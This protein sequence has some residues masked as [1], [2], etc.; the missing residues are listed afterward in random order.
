[1]SQKEKNNSIFDIQAN[2]GEDLIPKAT[3]S[4]KPL[5]TKK[6]TNTK[7]VAPTFP[8]EKD[9]KKTNNIKAK[10][11]KKGQKKKKQP[12]S[13]KRQKDTKK[14]T[15]E[16][17]QPDRNSKN[18]S[19]I[20][21]PIS[22]NKKQNTQ[23]ERINN[24]SVK[25]NNSVGSKKIKDKSI[26]DLLPIRKSVYDKRKYHIGYLMK[27]YKYMNIF[28]VISQDYP[29]I[30]EVDVCTQAS[31]F[32]MTY[33]IYDK[34]I[35]FFGLNMPV[36]TRPNVNY[37][38]MKLKKT[39]KRAYREILRNNIKDLQNI[40]I[41]TKQSYAMIFADS[42]EEI[43]EKNNIIISHLCAKGLL[44][45]LLVEEKEDVLKKLNNPFI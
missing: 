41:Q 9:V 45:P 39:K 31:H 44:R 38:E 40:E 27:N 5:Q 25:K 42:Y 18:V 34:S 1:M 35:K 24:K 43:I 14:K 22:H 11:D 12:S 8:K 19:K 6:N 28:G 26:L 16:K 13:I 37:F 23:G 17:K 10:E 32:D 29:N 2:N 33:R 30:S 36:D 7:K 4:N 15:I 3:V 20:K 21:P